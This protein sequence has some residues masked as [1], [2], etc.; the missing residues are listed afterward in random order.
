MSEPYHPSKVKTLLIAVLGKGGTLGFSKHAYDEMR[1]DNM[2]EVDVRNVLKGGAPQ[3]GEIE[4]GTWRY[5]VLTRTMAAVVAFRNET[6]AVVIT[7]WRLRK[8]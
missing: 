3:P 1:K 4:K 6:W 5:R 7:A 2:T 8:K